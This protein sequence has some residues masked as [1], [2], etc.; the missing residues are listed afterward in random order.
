M[1]S[2]RS[3]YEAT[4]IVSSGPLASELLWIA[5]SNVQ[6]GMAAT[7]ASGTDATGVNAGVSAAAA[8]IAVPR[9]VAISET[10]RYGCLIAVSS[11]LGS[12]FLAGS[13]IYERRI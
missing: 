7:T 1:T 3:L 8:V 9:T 11:G 6:R 13:A 5:P 12:V 2:G 10:R 4:A